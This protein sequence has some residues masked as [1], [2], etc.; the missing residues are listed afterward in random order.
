MKKFLKVFKKKKGKENAPT[1]DD[2]EEAMNQDKAVAGPSQEDL[3]RKRG[4][5]K[6]SK[7]KEKAQEFPQ[8]EEEMQV[9]EQGPPPK[10]PRGRPKG[11]KNKPKQN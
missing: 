11:S 4:R 8:E 7:N 9:E 1:K 3:P 2:K 5:P 10:R 6:E